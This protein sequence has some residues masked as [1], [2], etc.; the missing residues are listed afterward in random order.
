MSTYFIRRNQRILG[1]L[2]KA[3]VLELLAT[4]RVLETDE[5]STATE[6]P[7]SKAKPIL[8]ELST[9]PTDSLFAQSENQASETPPDIPKEPPPFEIDFCSRG[10]APEHAAQSITSSF[11]DWVHLDITN[12]PTI[13]YS[14]WTTP[15][16]LS[17]NS[18]PASP[19]QNPINT[20][21]HTKAWSL[22]S[23]KSRV[24]YFA[25]GTS[26][27]CLI[28]L[29]VSIMVVRGLNTNNAQNISSAP[30]NTSSD[31]QP[32]PGAP[33]EKLNSFDTYHGKAFV[34]ADLGGT[35]HITIECHTGVTIYATWKPAAKHTMGFEI[36][37]IQTNKPQNELGTM[38]IVRD[39]IAQHLRTQK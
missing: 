15:L 6:G 24:I 5:V 28:T 11:D 20:T 36:I 4:E 13:P 31:Q 27:G 32:L 3:Q 23:Q 37:S 10:L 2:D 12:T 9:A 21:S 30:P 34:N 26:L 39:A 16:E 18:P 17:L 19:L 1:P 14:E 8:V 35:K 7:W 22:P 33:T 38:L 25:T 29:I